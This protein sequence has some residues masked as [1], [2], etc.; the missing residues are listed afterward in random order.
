[1]RETIK[2][3]LTLVLA[4]TIVMGLVGC[5]GPATTIPTGDPISTDG[6]NSGEGNMNNVEVGEVTYPLQTDHKLSIWCPS[7][8]APLY[9]GYETYEQSPW[10]S[11]LAEQT[12]VE[13]EWRYPVAGANSKQAY[14]LLMMNETLPDIISFGIDPGEAQLL[15]NEGVLVDLKEYLPKYAPDYWEYITAPGR[16]EY[17]RSVTTEEGQIYM[18]RL[19]IENDHV[20]YGPV[21]RKDW[22]DE[23]NL[24]IPKTIAD[25]EVM[26]KTFKDKYG[27]KFAFPYDRFVIAGL[28]SGFGAYTTFDGQ[29]YLDNGEIK[30]SMAQPEY[31]EYLGTLARWVEE[32]LLDVDSLTMT[33]EGFRTK[34]INDNCG[35]AFVVMSLYTKILSDAAAEMS[36]AE[37]VAV[38]YPVVEEGQP[39]NWVQLNTQIYDNGCYITTSCSE[40]KL[41]TALKWLNYAYTE[42]G[43]NYYNYGVEND[44]YTVDENGVVAFTD[45]ILK[46][47]DSAASACLKYTGMGNV[48][49]CGVQLTH[50]THIKNDPVVA[51]GS[52]LWGENT[53]TAEHIIPTLVLTYDEASKFANLD[54]A[55]NT[56][57]TEI[58]MKVVAGEMDISE[59]DKA[60]QE[61]DKLGLQDALGIM[62]AAYQRHLK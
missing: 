7:T 18:F 55:V 39:T 21:V 4:L 53:E 6:Q 51:E 59:W 57:C 29:Y 28:A 3:V 12:G 52:K 60:A 44:T 33:D 58:A 26:L 62:N 13:V 24:D 43:I 48:G 61:M 45:K 47:R 30:Y 8:T 9:K 46:D 31:K 1:M 50:F 38:P 16:E 25:W 35:A 27:A 49:I 11:G 17:L 22:L 2:R 32:G 20:P 37:W 15:Y 56:Y 41:I 54:N 40:E 5:G 19:F 14:H 23:C 42:E 36:T 10:H 34:A